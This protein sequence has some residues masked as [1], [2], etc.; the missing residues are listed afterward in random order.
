MAVGEG[1][2]VAEGQW[3]QGG[4]M[5][6]AQWFKPDDAAFER[7]PDWVEFGHPQALRTRLKRAMVAA[8]ASR[9]AVALNEGLVS[10]LKA[11]PAPS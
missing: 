11:C 2:P 10:L 5:P 7:G 3:Q 4:A 9:A 6:F 8:Q 1:G